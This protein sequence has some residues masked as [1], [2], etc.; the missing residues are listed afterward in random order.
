MWLIFIILG[1]ICLAMLDW[2]GNWEY[3]QKPQW[4]DNW[5]W[6]TIL[7]E[8]FDKHIEYLKNKVEEIHQQHLRAYARHIAGLE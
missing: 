8:H 7:T 3:Y 5:L 2:Y 4:L 6:K 1:C